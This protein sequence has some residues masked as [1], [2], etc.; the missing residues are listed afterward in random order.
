VPYA[1]AADMIARYGEEE[2]IH[3]SV[4]PGQ[5]D[6]P[7][8]LVAIENALVDSSAL[9][10]SYLR[11]RYLAPLVTPI[12]AEIARAARVLARYDLAHGEQ[13]TP[14]EQMRL[15]RKEVLAWLEQL[16]SGAAQLDGVPLAGGAGAGARVKDRPRAFSD[17]SLR[18]W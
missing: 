7:P 2:M 9:I 8:D 5:L 14:T 13:K 16:A 17:C 6:G 11:R 1:T 18:G 3:L 12:P 4:A 10:D 15:D